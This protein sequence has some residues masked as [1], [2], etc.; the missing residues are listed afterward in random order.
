MLKTFRNCV[1]GVLKTFFQSAIEKSENYLSEHDPDAMA[2][3]LSY[4]EKDTFESRKYK[5]EMYEYMR[6]PWNPS[7]HDMRREDVHKRRRTW[8]R[9]TTLNNL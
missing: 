3:N 6:R 5:T 1:S 8:R 9:E 2:K 7:I 4:K